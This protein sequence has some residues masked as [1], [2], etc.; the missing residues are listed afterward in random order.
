[1]RGGAQ[2]GAEL[3][4]AE[5][6]RDL[7]LD[8]LELTIDLG[9]DLAGDKGA[10]AAVTTGEEPED[11]VDEVDPDGVAHGAD[12]RVL[13][14]LVRVVVGHAQEE[15]GEEAEGRDPEDEEEEVPGEKAG[16][17]DEGLRDREDYRSDGA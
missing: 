17:L 16:R 11:G 6:V 7:A 4:L 15:H 2:L 14:P 10:E 12:A 13:V 5:A 3:G 1:M 9:V 8:L